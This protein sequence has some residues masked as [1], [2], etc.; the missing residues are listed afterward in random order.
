MR[1][2]EVSR[3]IG[4]SISIILAVILPW[5]NIAHGIISQACV[6]LF[7]K[8]TKCQGKILEDSSNSGDD[9]LLNFQLSEKLA[10]VFFS[11]L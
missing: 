2:Y 7:S 9:T 11:F 8:T 3:T 6:L 4:D 5:I 1:I 10:K